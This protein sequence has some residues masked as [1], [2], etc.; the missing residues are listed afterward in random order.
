M[1]NPCLLI[2][3]IKIFPETEKRKKNKGNKKKKKNE[4]QMWKRRVRPQKHMQTRWKLSGV[5]HVL[6]RRRMRKREKCQSGTAGKTHSEG[7]WVLHC[8]LVVSY[9][10]IWVGFPFFTVCCC[11]FRP[12]A[13]EWAT[14]DKTRVGGREN[15]KTEK[16]ILVGCGNQILSWTSISSV[17]VCLSLF[18]AIVIAVSGA[19]SFGSVGCQL[20]LAVNG[21]SCSDLCLYVNC[22]SYPRPKIKCHSKWI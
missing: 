8:S 9:I 17:S 3:G 14:R 21:D 12:A 19:V 10:K 16:Y 6:R 15:G 4:K 22:T 1:F 7:P 20:W 11:Y 18:W 5:L 13:V 2:L